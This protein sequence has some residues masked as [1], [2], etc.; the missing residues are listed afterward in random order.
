MV[1]NMTARPDFLSTIEVKLAVTPRSI[2]LTLASTGSF[3][4]RPSSMTASSYSVQRSRQLDKLYG[5]FCAIE[6]FSGFFK[7]QDCQ[8]R[9]VIEPRRIEEEN[10]TERQEF[11]SLFNDV[12]CRP[13]NGR[14]DGKVLPDQK[15][16]KARF[17]DIS[18]F[19][20]GDMQSISF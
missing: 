12:S 13:R 10:G 5:N 9:C 17:P 7:A 8:S 14:C 2:L 3:R 19:Q 20:N 16:Q 15:I 1:D 4:F 6:Y 11:R 18:F